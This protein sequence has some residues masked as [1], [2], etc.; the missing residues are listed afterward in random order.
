MTGRMV[1]TS[2]TTRTRPAIAGRPAVVRI[3]IEGDGQA[4]AARWVYFDGAWVCAPCRRPVAKDSP[5]DLTLSADPAI[6]SI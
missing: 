2:D 1:A 3:F 4:I 6:M 5:V